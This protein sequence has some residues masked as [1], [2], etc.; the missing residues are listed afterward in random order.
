M[1][2]QPLDFIH[3]PFFAPV[4]LCYTLGLKL[5]AIKIRDALN[6][7]V[8]VD[9]VLE[10]DILPLLSCDFVRGVL[11]RSEEFLCVKAINSFYNLAAGNALTGIFF[12]FA[13]VFGVLGSKRFTSKFRDRVRELRAQA[14]AVQRTIRRPRRPEQRSRRE[15]YATEFK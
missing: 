14:A 4:D 6:F 15:T 12:G 9:D 13:T 3:T 7:I 1:F 2:S 11:D 5:A 8:E 10:S